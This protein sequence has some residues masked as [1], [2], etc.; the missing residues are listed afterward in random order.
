L[1]RDIEK[2]FEDLD[3]IMREVD[4]MVGSQEVNDTR[5]GG[6]KEYAPGD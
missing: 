2:E 6:R 5:G 3:E 1:L 4:S